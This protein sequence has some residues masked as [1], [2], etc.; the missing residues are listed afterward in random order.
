[1]VIHN[2]LLLFL[3]CKDGMSGLGLASLAAAAILAVLSAISFSVNFSSGT[4]DGL[5][6]GLSSVN[7]NC[8]K[9]GQQKDQPRLL[10]VQTEKQ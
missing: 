6:K 9:R 5:N 8:V 2:S 4:H 3:D 7:Q 1:M 10:G